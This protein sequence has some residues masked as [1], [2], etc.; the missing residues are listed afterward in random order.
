VD[1]LAWKPDRADV[2]VATAHKT[3]G[4]ESPRVLIGN[5]FHE[6]EQ[7]EDGELGELSRE[8]MMLNYVA[9]TR[10]QDAL[11]LGGLAWGRNYLPDTAS[12]CA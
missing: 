4:L 10:A 3:K 6:P 1:R 5:D 7:T 2:Q 8:E 11:D 12:A 9:M